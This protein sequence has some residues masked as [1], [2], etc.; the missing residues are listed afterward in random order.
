MGFP[1]PFF[2]NS[3][4]SL[5]ETGELIYYGTAAINLSGCS[6]LLKEPSDPAYNKVCRLHMSFVS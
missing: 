5:S 1:F 6:H 4:A 2:P 3:P